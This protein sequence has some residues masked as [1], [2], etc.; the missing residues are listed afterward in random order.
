MVTSR[1]K[2]RS[3]PVVRGAAWAVLAAASLA[4]CG[5]PAGD[6]GDR[7]AAPVPPADPAPPSG[8]PAG[9]RGF[10]YGPVKTAAEYLA[11]PELA[12]A[13]P[14]RGELLGLACAACHTLQAGGKTIVGPNLHGVFGRR[15]AALPDFEY[16]AALRSS[17]LTWTPR[18][19]QAWLAEPGRFVAGTTMT[20][21]GYQSVDDRRDLIAYLL[22]ATD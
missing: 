16:S 17:G 18:A 3:A 10:D 2:P 1:S 14:V 8:A 7:A 19:L 22:R 13:N 9:A 6:T 20:F 12:A 11:E 21:T 5:P 4:G 15:A